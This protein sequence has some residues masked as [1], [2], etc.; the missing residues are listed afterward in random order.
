M[1][2]LAQVFDTPTQQKPMKD[3]K[4]ARQEEI[5]KHAVEKKETEKTF[6]EE[7]R[8][9]YQKELQER[10][11]QQEMQ[12]NSGGYQQQKDFLQKIEDSTISGQVVSDRMKIQKGK[13]HLTPQ[14]IVESYPE[15]NNNDDNGQSA[16]Q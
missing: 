10:L 14:G 2:E 6:L 7:E 5:I 8:E 9:Q 4:I 12:L 15:E 3:G 13:G 1:E 16:E 11:K